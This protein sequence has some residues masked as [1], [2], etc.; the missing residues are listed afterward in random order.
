MIRRL[1]TLLSAL[2][3][4][5]C[6]ATCV[7]WVRSYQV[8]DRLEQTRTY[9]SDGTDVSDRW[10]EFKDAPNTTTREVSWSSMGAYLVY[11]RIDWVDPKG[12]H[13]SAPGAVPPPEW[14]RTAEPL[15]S[16][17][18][19]I[20]DHGG[21]TFAGVHRDG[22]TMDLGQGCRMRWATTSFPLWF[23]PAAFAL[24]PLVWSVRLARGRRRNRLGL[25]QICG[26]DLR[27]SPD[28]CPECGA[29][30]V[31]SRLKP[32]TSR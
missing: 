26:Y 12:G 25:C 23:A 2:S 30:A 5:L 10:D 21:Q 15:A 13:N 29:A 24:L 6:V 8:W 28:R 27:A 32:L 3:L 1:F 22:G 31:A 7:L 20:R 16:G 14:R 19:P 11:H 4:L 18:G 17:D 9:A